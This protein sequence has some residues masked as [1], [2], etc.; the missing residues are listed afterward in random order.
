MPLSYS[1]LNV[2]VYYDVPQKKSIKL[3]FSFK[4]TISRDI[5]FVWESGGIRWDGSVW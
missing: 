2:Y 4:S 3:I 1:M 5:I